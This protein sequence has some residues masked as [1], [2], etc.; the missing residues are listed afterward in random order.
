MSM[1]ITTFKP[2]NYPPAPE[3][4]TAESQL[5]KL[6]QEKLSPLM[7]ELD[8]MEKS[9][10]NSIDEIENKTHKIKK[11]NKDIKKIKKNYLNK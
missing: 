9:L 3:K 6:F 8:E 1:K 10:S 2:N 7:H 4:E 11:I 5:H